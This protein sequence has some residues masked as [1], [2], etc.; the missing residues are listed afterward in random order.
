MEEPTSESGPQ[1]TAASAASL[2]ALVIRQ[3]VPVLSLLGV[4][5]GDQPP[6]LEG[7]GPID[8]Q[9]AAGLAART[10]TPLRVLVHP[11]SQAVL[12]FERRK[13]RIDGRLREYLVYISGRRSFPAC[14][15]P[16]DEWSS[17]QLDRPG[18]QEWT[19]PTGRRYLSDPVR[20]GAPPGSA[21]AA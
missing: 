5:V 13:Y 9:T 3:T 17:R 11:V 12:A 6:T 19:S 16:A 8:L 14:R 2:E 7:C 15:R 4:G 21:H 10:S 20:S 1:S 18:L